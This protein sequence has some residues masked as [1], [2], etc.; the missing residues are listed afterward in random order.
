MCTCADEKKAKMSSLLR[1]S[2]L[3]LFRYLVYW[4]TGTSERH[5]RTMLKQVETGMK[6]VG[7]KPFSLEGYD[8]GGG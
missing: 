1:L 3:P 2:D 8:E 6:D 7:V 4:Q 5:V